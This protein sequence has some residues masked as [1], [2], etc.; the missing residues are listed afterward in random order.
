[1]SLLFSRILGG[2]NPPSGS[3]ADLRASP[4]YW[5]TMHGL[6]DPYENGVDF[7]EGI[8]QKHKRPQ[9]HMV[10][11]SIGPMTPRVLCGDDLSGEIYVTMSGVGWTH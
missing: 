6:P 2:L 4:Q 3:T 7:F 10:K 11:T 8:A 1:L 5:L 9:F